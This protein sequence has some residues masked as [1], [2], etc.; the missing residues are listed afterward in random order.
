M[1]NAELNK[2]SIRASRSTL[3]QCV[4]IFP[5]HNFSRMYILVI[6]FYGLERSDTC[7]DGFNPKLSAKHFLKSVLHAIENVSR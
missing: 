6:H 1:F 5:N 2:N 4:L 7:Y 3:L